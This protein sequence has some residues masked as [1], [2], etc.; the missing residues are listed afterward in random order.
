MVLS[1]QNKGSTE[2]TLGR[3]RLSA[4]TRPDALRA[5]NL[6]MVVRRAIHKGWTRLGASALLRGD[7]Q[8]AIAALTRATASAGGCGLDHFLLALAH[9]DLEQR[10]ESRQ[11]AERGIA[12]LTQNEADERLRQT[13]LEVLTGTLGLSEPAAAERLDRLEQE[14]RRTTQQARQ[15]GQRAA[16]LRRPEHSP[17]LVPGWTDRGLLRAS[18]RDWASAAADFGH[19][20]ALAPED[21]LTGF[22]WAVLVAESGDLEG[23]RR[24]CRRLLD[25][26]DQTQ[27]PISARRICRAILAAPGSVTD[28]TPLRRMVQHYAALTPRD[29]MLPIALAALSA[30]AGESDEALRRLD[31][32]ERFVATSPRYRIFVDLSRA[33]LLARTG[34]ATR[35]HKYL[36]R[37]RQAYDVDL[38]P[39]P[40]R[41]FGNWTVNGWWEWIVVDL[42]RRDVEA[43][44]RAAD[45]PADPFTP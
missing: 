23:Y 24:A 25:Q 26:F 44:L 13:A 45:F 12:W 41:P 22:Q 35:S 6:R 36:A 17:D 8:A 33:L 19:A 30:S 40:G 43:L 7:R 18:E 20:F 31:E 5:E 1:L 27:D 37:A 14:G 38:K 11:W 29:P 42:Q 10:P 15:R 3:L 39:A 4:T 21:A 2:T 34:D 28:W 9:Q 32:A 16:V